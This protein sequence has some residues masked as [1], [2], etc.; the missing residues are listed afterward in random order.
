MYPEARKLS[1]QQNIDHSEVDSNGKK[2]SKNFEKEIW[3]AR[4]RANGQ[5]NRIER[6]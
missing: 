3:G 5:L 4:Y 1:D 6:Y 2:E